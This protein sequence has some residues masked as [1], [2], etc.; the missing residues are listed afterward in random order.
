MRRGVIITMTNG[1]ASP[2]ATP[3][4][5]HIS[6]RC[7]QMHDTEGNRQE[8]L[9]IGDLGDVT[10]VE[11][12]HKIGYQIA[13][14]DGR[15]PAH[16][17]FNAE[18]EGRRG[19]QSRRR[20]WVISDAKR[21]LSLTRACICRRCLVC[22]SR[23]ESSRAAAHNPRRRRTPCN[24][25]RHQEDNAITATESIRTILKPHRQTPHPAP[26]RSAADN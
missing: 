21:V 12:Q 17:K 6:E 14:G 18:T 19:E 26:A 11:T 25:A 22:P 20:R 2:T 15:T 23:K 8:E 4:P 13:L 16:H 9:D 5:T 3:Q 7:R 10:F 1:N 24:T